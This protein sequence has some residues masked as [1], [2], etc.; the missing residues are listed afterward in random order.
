M[1]IRER[2]SVKRSLPVIWVLLALALLALPLVFA[3][4]AKKPMPVAGTGPQTAGGEE[5]VKPVTPRASGWKEVE[6]LVSEQKYEAAAT[7]VEKI[8]A[9]SKARVDEPE[10]TRALV[11]L[12]QL[13][14]GLHGY[15]T[16]VRRLREEPWPQAPLQRAVLDLFYAHAIVEYCQSYSWEIGKRERVEAKGEVDLKAWTRDQLYAEAQRAYLEVWR[17]RADLGSTPVTTLKE[18]ITPND[19]PAGVRDTLRDA[20]SYLYADLLADSSFWTAEQSNDLFRL[21]RAQLLGDGPRGQASD[22]LLDDAKAHPLQKLVAVLGDL[23]AWQASRGHR[24]AELEARL[25]RLRRLHEALDEA[26]DRALVLSDLT[27]RLEGFRSVPWWSMGMALEAEFTRETDR[28]DALVLARGI[29]MAGRKAYPTSVG[30]Q[31]C[32]N[33]VQSIEAPDFQIAGMSLDAADR[34]SLGA[35]HRN[36]PALYFRAYP[37][38]LLERIHSS[39][40]YNLLPQ[41]QEVRA[42]LNGGAPAARWSVDLPSTPDYRSHRTFVTPPSLPK[43]AYLIAASA[44]E[45]FTESANRILALHFTVSDLVLLTRQEV[46][47]D[48]EVTALDGETG[49]PVSGATVSL[50]R[51]DWQQGHQEAAH[52]VSGEDGVVRFTGGHGRQGR[53]FFLLGQKGRDLS[54]DT[55]HLGFYERSQPGNVTASLVYTD[56]SIY[57]PGQKVFWKVL[58]YTGT[59]R[60]GRYKAFAQ[61]PVTV[62]LRD[63]NNEAV[64]SASVTTNGFGS[65]AGEFVVPSGKV[66]GRWRLDTSL[67]GSSGIRVEEYKR[68]TFEAAIKDPAEPLRLN[69]PATLTGEVKYYFG[70]PVTNGAVKWRVTREPVYPWWWG[71]YGWGRNTQPQT[72]ASGSSSLKEDGTF[73]VKFTPE[74]DERDGTSKDVTYRY[75][76][77]AD[78]TDEGGETRSA[79]K[80][81]RLGFVSVEA[82]LDLDGDFLRAGVAGKATATRSDLNG[83][84]KA[85]KGSWRLVALVQPPQTLL[86]ADQPVLKNE[87]APK[88]AY[89]TKGDQLRARWAPNYQPEAVLHGWAE[90]L[91]KAQG[92]ADHGA[93]GE[94]DI[95][96]PALP[97]GAY[98]LLYETTDDF[99][100]VCKASKDIL[101]AS[102]DAEVAL[103]AICLSENSTVPVGG[104]AR[105]LVH[106]GLP[107]QVIFLDIYKDGTRV[108]RRRLISDKDP[109]LMEMSVTERDRGGFGVTMTVLRDHQVMQFSRS[110]FVPWDDKELKVEFATFR[111]KLKPGGRETWRVTVKAPGENSAEPR[112]A[113][114][115]AYMY[116]RSLDL[117]AP[118]NPPRI[119]SLYPNRSGT[120][121]SRV[122][123]GQASSCYSQDWN[124]V[125]LP[126]YPSLREDEL[127]FYD[128]YGIGGPGRRYRRG[129]VLGGMVSESAPMAA[130]PPSPMA[131]KS[132]ASG[133]LA[134]DE[135]A[136]SEEK[137]KKAD[138][139]APAPDQVGGEAP[140]PEI[141]SNFSETA[142]WQPQLLTGTD[143]SAAIEFTVPDSVTSWNVWV[144]AVTKDLKGGSLHKEARS[145][146]DLMVRPYLPR[147]LRE[148]D[149]AGIKVVVNNASDHD[150]SGILTFD[151]LDPDT[152]ESLLPQFGLAAASAKLPFTVKKGGGSNLTFPI[153]APVRVGTVAFKVTATAGDTSD[154]ELRPLPVLPG[155][156]HLMQS[157]FV[158]LKNKDRK[159]L[160]FPDLAKNDDP[161]LVNEQM[162]V[163]LDAQLFYSV[164]SA[165]P[166][167]VNYPYECTEQ[168]LN[169]FLSTGILTSLYGQ[170]PAVGRMAAEFS[171]RD[172][173]LETW[174][175][176]DPNRKMTLEETPWLAES[177]GGRD[178]GLGTVNVLDPRIAKANRDS[179]LALLRKA[180]TSNGAFPWWAG[181]PPSPYMTLYILYG[182]S[183]GLEFQVDV[184]RDMV[185]RAWGYMHQHYLDEIVRDMM[186]KDCC[187]EFVTFLNYVLSNYPDTSWTGGVFTN[188]E[189]RA[190]LDF[191]FKH[192]K[193]HSP[194]NKCQLALTLHRMGRAKDA[195]LVFSSVMDSA[196][197]NPEEGTFWAPEDRGW[198]WY[199][200]TIETHA[201]ALR[202]LMEITPADAKKDGLVQWIFLNKKLNHW[203][204]TRA[205]AE[206]IYSLVHYLQKEGALGT[207]ES[208]TVRV[209]NQVVQYTFEPDKYT[210]KK[211][212]TVITGDK[213]DAETCSTVVVEKETKGFMFASA[214]WLFSTERL[215]AEDRGDFLS[216]HRTYF[217]RE[218][219]GGEWVLSPL[220]EGAVIAPGDQVEIQLSIRCKHPC[221]YVHLRDPRAAGMEPENAVSRFK[222]DLGIGWYEETRDSG[223]N[224]FFEWLPQ[225]EYTFKYRL[226]ANMA[227]TFK[228]SPATLQSM[229]APEFSA[230]SAGAVLEVKGQ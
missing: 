92:T 116:D 33:I 97:T 94:A 139:V 137:D 144:H 122:N 165:T 169:R 5:V 16:A 17:E 69:R 47:G 217:K 198:L 49:W 212:Q 166:Y 210:G 146:K 39:K 64:A 104:T 154:G 199:N 189:R 34:R 60:D 112:A 115:L 29:A 24:E 136:R 151:I 108:E 119:G 123:L 168:T 170:Y 150:L 193:Q 8:L 65:A 160:T 218:Q 205:T 181:G 227:G 121:T 21:D 53:N 135:A 78:V 177:R 131:M 87:G 54:L 141:R 129:G 18:Y 84:P 158:T 32:D 179:A 50:Y 91:Q 30:G 15:E 173:P 130:P 22:V 216:V 149:R 127:A 88:D 81:F 111:D 46:D 86:P 96:I 100:A 68:P 228:V 37:V 174:D 221:E 40:D 51:Y 73:L 128:S 70:L 25:E 178:A 20:V 206:V 101:V 14:M 98:R 85:G 89:E 196:K 38:D 55:A 183:K 203:K 200:D 155:R 113:E 6:R 42:I 11:R 124:F 186:G 43:G 2:L 188:A 83:T 219:K 77:H 175:A 23:E 153:T 163:T 195:A 190:M 215:P 207:R 182:F 45:D 66:L 44:R 180:Q 10:W 74:V 133:N 3:Q 145:V 118:H 132:Q 26:P 126:A 102:S 27:S 220:A 75:V 229:Y 142:F 161:S 152:N 4:R 99:G 106:S 162:V 1:A 134:K 143:G 61:S 59:V 194:Y 95:A 224:F 9:A 12:T 176:A 184:P 230:Y 62:T 167:L 58:A 140:A 109:S 117:F 213:I 120:G 52:Q 110:V 209:C 197:S 35:D 105:F 93:K 72:V 225:G 159:E 172:T 67:S 79:S 36:M 171:K 187:W 41:W 214:T 204:S 90:G 192:W 157:R 125:N 185:E 56:R 57:R 156:M 48:I 103:P 80:G 63:G 147:F 226:R 114:L 31:R 222:W 71:W 208:A 7:Q 191:S 76:L 164:L 28:P 202:T 223:T 138:A 148:G 211:A 107:G 13:R 201:F 82:R 19:Y